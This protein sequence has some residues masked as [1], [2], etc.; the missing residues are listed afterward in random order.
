MLNIT[1]N[2]AHNGSR[3]LET[4]SEMLAKQQVGGDRS[5]IAKR[6]LKS[7]NSYKGKSSKFYAILKTTNIRL[8]PV[9]DNSFA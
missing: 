6:F 1:T 8:F 5:A 2:S 3:R 4:Q 9:N 7:P